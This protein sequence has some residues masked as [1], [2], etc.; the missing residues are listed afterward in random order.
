MGDFAERKA[1]LSGLGMSEVGRRMERS[2]LQLTIDAIQ[3]A[4]RDAGLAMSEIDGIATFPGPI[5]E[6]MPGFVGPDLGA[7][8]DALGIE[9][10]WH[11]STFQGASPI[12]PLIHAILAVAGGLCRHAVVFRCITESSGQGTGGRG[13]VGASLGEADGAYEWLLPVG[14]VSGANWA[15]LYAT[16][17][18]AEYGTTKEQLGWVSVTQRFHAAQHRDAILTQPLTM[19]EYLS[20]RMISTPLGLYDCDIPVD[21]CTAIVVSTAASEANLRHSVRIEAMGTAMRHRPRWDQWQDMTTMAAHDAA[22]QLWSRTDLK[23]ADVDAAQLYDGFSCYTLFWL[24][25]FGFCSKGQA[26]PFV[27]GGQ[28]I[29][30][31]GILPLNTFGG[32]LSGGRLHGWGFVA[33]AMRQL[34]GEA[35]GIQLSDA[36]VIAVG[37]GGGIMCGALLLTRL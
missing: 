12:G 21:G 1:I 15:A 35:R 14:A 3:A 23:P 2:S 17:H 20:A 16:R 13:G 37:V 33:E 7:V 26:G 8:Q 31:G 5:P 29:S 36:E 11:M 9:A 32:Q 28:R 24:E 27:D 30:S 4:V 18:M 6:L 19:A 25:A 22:A 10:N 34:R